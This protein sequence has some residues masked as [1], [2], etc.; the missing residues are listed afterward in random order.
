MIVDSKTMSEIDEK[1]SKVAVP[2]MELME[3]AGTV[4]TDEIVKKYLSHNKVNVYI[5]VGAGNNGGDGFVIARLLTKMKYNVTTIV[6]AE[7][8][9]IRYDSHKNYLKLIK[10]NDVKF[11]KTIK[12][13]EKLVP[14]HGKKVI[15]DA[16]FGT[17]LTRGIH[18]IFREAIEYINEIKGVKV[19][20]DIPSGV[21]SDTGK[22][23][24]L[25]V[26]AHLTVTFGL[27]K[28]GQFIHP[29]KEMCGKLRIKSIGFPPEIIKS[30][31]INDNLLAVRTI[32]AKLKF[33]SPNSHKNDYGH[34]LV[35]SGSLGKAG[36]A[37]LVSNGTL[38]AGA[39]LATLFVPDSIYTP[40]ASQLVETMVEPISSINDEIEFE[41]FK[42]AY[43]KIKTPTVIAIGPGIGITENIR[44]ILS[45]LL[46]TEVPLVIDADAVRMVKDLNSQLKE[47]NAPTLL[48]PHLGEFSFLTD[49]NINVL[50]DDKLEH[51]KKFSKENNVF[52]L[53]KGNDTII[54]T[55]DGNISINSSGNPGMSNAGQGDALTGFITGLLASG[56]EPR[57][58]LEVA[59]FIHGYA[60]DML[61]IENGP[62]GILASEIIK[63]FPKA[64]KKVLTK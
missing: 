24:G 34:A 53:L 3:N 51:V 38:K 23:Y 56:Y 13:V 4:T 35:V 55:P 59:A 2:S 57:R 22:I 46:E 63:Q 52:L 12:E 64:I 42:N 20:V 11:V 62:V 49:I 9:Q 39:G 47:R 8:D 15:V 27:P 58:A 14:K 5:F 48:T 43:N 41:A 61:Y 40:V 45:F 44:E 60:A 29:G 26:K 16:I 7:E 6:L 17:G 1:T 28:F 25:A 21:S 54:A 50:K 32:K 18:G 33:R 19:S 37:V 36:A 31:N 10:I 30:F